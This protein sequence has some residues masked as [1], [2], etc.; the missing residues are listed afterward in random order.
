MSSYY[1]IHK[2]DLH[3]ILVI[4]QSVLYSIQLYDL[5]QSMDCFEVPNLTPEQFEALIVKLA[6]VYSYQHSG[7]DLENL[8]KKINALL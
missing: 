5:N 7:P 6:E 8:K 4:E 3:E 1:T 2:K